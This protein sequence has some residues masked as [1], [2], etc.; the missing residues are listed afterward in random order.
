MSLRLQQMKKSK[1]KF[2]KSQMT[3]IDGKSRLNIFSSKTLAICTQL[4]NCLTT[5]WI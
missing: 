1:I 3:S 4:E 2:M 5:R